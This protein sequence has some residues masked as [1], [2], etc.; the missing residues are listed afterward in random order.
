MSARAPL[1]ST[2]RRLVVVSFSSNSNTA[3][4]IRS[5]ALGFGFFSLLLGAAGLLYGVGRKVEIIWAFVGGAIAL[6]LRFTVLRRRA[7]QDVQ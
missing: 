2:V 7:S 6:L 3:V 4:F 5:I 1:S